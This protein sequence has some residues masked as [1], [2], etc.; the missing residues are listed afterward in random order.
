MGGSAG[1]TPFGGDLLLVDTSVADPARVYNFWLGGKDHFEADRMAAAAGISAFPGT[2]QSVRADRAFLA[3]TV[4]YLA[5]AGIRQFI[6][7]GPGLPSMDNTHEVAQA[8]AI[9]SRVVYVDNDPVVLAHA[10]A[11]L[12]STAVG[13]TGYLNADLRDPERI[14]RDAMPLLDFSQPVAVL[15]VG[16]LHFIQDDEGPYQ[17]VDALMGALPGGSY[18][19]VSHLASD[20][21]P[22]QIA[23]FARAVGEHLGLAI[24]PRD[25]GAVSRFFSRLELVE[26]GVVQAPAWRPRTELESRAPAALWGGVARKPGRFPVG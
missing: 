15:L 2:V 5:E 19:A 20:L 16:I 23:A 22:E 12:T 17:I 6:D 13:A 26:P 14:L 7:I 21:Y 3:R 24:T 8:V 25:L 11:L 10:Q 1:G 4:R 9:D 18:L